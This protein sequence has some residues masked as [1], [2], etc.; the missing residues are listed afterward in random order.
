MTHL[1]DSQSH[2]FMMKKFAVENVSFNM[3]PI[4][5][6]S[7]YM[8]A[9]SDDKNAYIEEKPRHQ[10]TL[11]SYYLG[12]TLVTQELWQLIMGYNPS[13]LK[14]PNRPV[15]S[16]D[17]ADCKKFIKKLGSMLHVKFRLPTEAEWEYA[18]RG[19]QLSKKYLYAGSDDLDKVAWFYNNSDSVTH[20][21]ATKEPNELGLYDMMG[22]VNE[23]CSDWYA[24]SYYSISPSFNPQGPFLGKYKV[25]RGGSFVE[26]MKNCRISFRSYLWPTGMASTIGLRLAMNMEE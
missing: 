10:V 24:T 2:V 1:S 7:F 18:A 11:S 9:F 25:I 15:E 6:G 3:I 19:G 16:V 8:G 26:R 5:G 20:E 4:E 13:Y 22:N 12:Q 14:G 21:V 23:W 17:L